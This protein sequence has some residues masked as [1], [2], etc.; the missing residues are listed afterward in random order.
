[1]STFANY[2]FYKA[3]GGGLTETAYNAS[4]NDA[5]AEILLQTNGA[6]QAAPANMQEAVKLCE[7]ALVDVVAGYKDTAAAL[8]K[9]IGSISNDGYAVSVGMGGGVSIIKAEAQERA[10]VCARYLQWPV[11]LM[12]RWL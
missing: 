3:N 7:C 12:C 9:G 6:A 1:M 10:S 4:V 5:H 8:P 2:A 11:N